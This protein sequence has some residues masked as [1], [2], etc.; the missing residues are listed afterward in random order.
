MPSDRPA[1]RPRARHDITTLLGVDALQRN[2]RLR[3][4]AHGLRLGKLA[5]R[6]GVYPAP[7]PASIRDVRLVPD[8]VFLLTST[9]SGSTVLRLILN[10]HSRICAP[11]E[12]QMNSF[13]VSPA[14]KRWVGPPMQEMGLSFRDFEN[15]LW[16]YMLYAHLAVSGKQIIVDKTPQNMRSWKRIAKFWPE[17]RYIHLRRHPAAIHNSRLRWLPEE[18]TDAGLRTINAYGRRLNAAREALPGPTVRYEDLTERPEQ[19]VRGICEYLG[20]RYE[21][22][23]LNYDTGQRVGIV[24]GLGDLGERIESGRIQPTHPLPPAEEIP[25]ELRELCRQWGYL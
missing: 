20:V 5:R 7:R 8:P 6:V 23:M 25:E 17:A 19:T 13:K 3:A 14:R 10:T 2:E 9:R 4:L 18:P 24:S 22:A 16:D 11:H 15:M 21:P 12:L 1:A